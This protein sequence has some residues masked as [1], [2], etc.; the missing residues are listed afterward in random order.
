[1]RHG[2]DFRHMKSGMYMEGT[3]QQKTNSRVAND[4]GDRER[5]DPGWTAI[6]SARA[7]TGEPGSGDS[8]LVVD[9]WRWS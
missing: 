4:F 1:M 5:A 6:P 2:F 8:P 9:T 7:D 3:G